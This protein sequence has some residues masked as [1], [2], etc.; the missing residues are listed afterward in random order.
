MHD[1]SSCH[2]LTAFVN[3]ATAEALRFCFPPRPLEFV[4]EPCLELETLPYT[5]T[6]PFSRAF[7]ARGFANARG[8]RLARNSAGMSDSRSEPLVIDGLIASGHLVGA[9]ERGW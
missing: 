9:S 1:S 4:R 5:R 2:A 8:L 7:L 3:V 6:G